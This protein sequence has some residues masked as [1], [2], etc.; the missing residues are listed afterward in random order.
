MRIPARRPGW[1]AWRV[2][3]MS[4]PYVILREWNT[5]EESIKI[6]ILGLFAPQGAQSDD[7]GGQHDGKTTT[8]NNPLHQSQV[9]LY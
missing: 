1:R 4:P 8:K 6:V 7:G 3:R 9:F 5:T 2:C